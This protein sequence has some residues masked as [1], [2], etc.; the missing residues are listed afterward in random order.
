MEGKITKILIVDDDQILLEMYRERL[1]FDGYEIAIAA[2]GEAA[3]DL[4]Q[5][6]LPDLILMDIVMPRMNG[7]EAADFL[8]DHPKTARI[9]IIFFTQLPG[10]PLDGASVRFSVPPTVLAKKDYTPQTLAEFIKQYLNQN[11]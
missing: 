7:L 8:Q 6:F 5:S 11:R 2:D 1:S 9:P 4:A 3:L 10:N